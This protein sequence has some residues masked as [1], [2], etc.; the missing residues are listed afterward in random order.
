MEIE[1]QMR[2]VKCDII[3]EGKFQLPTQCVSYRLQTWPEQPVMHNQ[4]IDIF[5]RSFG[6]DAG[7]NID[8][9][10]NLRYATGVFDLQTVKRI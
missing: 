1:R 6:Q 9:R 10:T 8:G 3:L 2:A 5:F 7:R 4:K